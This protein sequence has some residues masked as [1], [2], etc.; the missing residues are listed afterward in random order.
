VLLLF[1]CEFSLLVDING[2][3]QA[4]D[5]EFFFLFA[6]DCVI[7]PPDLKELYRIYQQEIHASTY[8]DA[9]PSYQVR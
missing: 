1:N 4:S 7:L 8:T 3:T 2:F 5:V 9:S 6:E